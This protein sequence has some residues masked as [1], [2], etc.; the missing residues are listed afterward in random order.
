M[1][2][3]YGLG[4]I[5]QSPPDYRNYRYAAPSDVLA[6]LPVSVDLR[7]SRAT[8]SVFNQGNLGSCTANAT[9]A[10]V[11]Y[12]ERR[13]GDP[14]WDR[15]SRLY[16]YYY[17]REKIG[18]INEDSG[19]LIADSIKVVAER[20]APRESFWPYEINR[21][22]DKPVVPDWRASQHRVM[23][24]RE[25]AQGSERDMQGCLA[26]GYPFTYGFA[27]YESFWEIGSDGRWPGTRGGIDGYHAVAIWGYDFTVGA[28]GFA[29]GGWIVRNSWSSNWG[30]KGY[31]YVPRTYMSVEAFDCWTVRKV[32]R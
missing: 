4:L 7:T 30:N 31:F 16:T 26:E 27:V 25:I 2:G 13:D 18:T 23:E 21:F 19:A 12:V 24:Y 29:N 11:Q 10:L 20:G 15:L 9:N 6:E 5:G 17:S 14:D 8:P 22:T 3:E 32:F 1:K 28:F